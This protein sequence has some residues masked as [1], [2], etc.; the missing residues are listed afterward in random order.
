MQEGAWLRLE[1]RLRDPKATERCGFA[2]WTPKGFDWVYRKFIQ[3]KVAGYEAILASPF[4]NRF[5]LDQVPDF[6]E[7]LKGSYDDNFFRQEVLGD[8]L[9]QKGG[10][11]YPA[12]SR[13]ANVQKSSADPGW[14]ICWA[15][16]FN[17]DPM[18]SLVVQM[19]DSEFRVLDE[20]VLHRA[21]TEQACEEFER[22]VGIPR[23][24]ITVFG[25]AA[26]AAM[27]TT[28]FSDYQVISEVLSVA[29]REGD[30][31]GAEC[32]SAGSGAGGGNERLSVERARGRAAAGGSQ[33]QGADCG[34]R[35]GR[36]Q[37]RFGAGG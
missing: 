17:V 36:L 11:V 33:V 14:A 29:K 27:Q 37:E 1:G 22:R 32:Q 34:F 12:F 8:Y 23:A 15:V 6:Y 5:L 20:I 3:D 18:S 24:G 13:E 10:L 19:K 21:T 26:G 31:S 30:L 16:D 25:D 28:G 4:E 35:A 7:R 9:N 2:V